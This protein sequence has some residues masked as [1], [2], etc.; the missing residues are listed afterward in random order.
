[1]YE[2]LAKVI[3]VYDGDSCT[4]LIDLGFNLTL[5]EK[6]RLYGIDTPELRSNNLQEKELAKK[7]RDYLKELVLNKTVTIETHKEGKYGR[8]LVNLYIGNI[9]INDMLV[10][11][12]YAKPY[13]G[14]KRES[15]F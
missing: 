12:G 8:Y 10:A 6:C 7:A 14:G 3:D 1:M 2:Y 4:I 15:W 11:E 5:K 9:L 13:Y